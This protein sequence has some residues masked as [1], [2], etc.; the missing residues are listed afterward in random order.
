MFRSITNDINFIKILFLLTKFKKKIIL[1]NKFNEKKIILNYTTCSS[2]VTK[3]YQNFYFKT[4][5]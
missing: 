2:N 5:F 3:F 1:N 4:F